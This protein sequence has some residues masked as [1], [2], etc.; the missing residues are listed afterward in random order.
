M[1]YRV[2]FSLQAQE[3]LA[4]L[5]RY[6]AD[7]ASPD[8]AAQYTE[9]IVSYCERLCAHPYRGTMR[10]DVR[11]GLRITNYRKRVVIAFGIEA[12]LVSIVGVFYGGRNYEAIL[13]DDADDGG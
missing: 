1:I 11:P 12:D 7:A 2:I 6:I 13:R 8:I 3:Q 10:D 5:Y 4:A 9:A